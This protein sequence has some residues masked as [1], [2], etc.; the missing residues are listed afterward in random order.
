MLLRGWHARPWHARAG[1]AAMR[2][3]SRLRRP[4]WHLLAVAMAPIVAC[5][6][7]TDPPPQP[8][9][10]VD[11]A[12]TDVRCPDKIPDQPPTMCPRL[13]NM[14]LGCGGNG[15]LHT[16]IGGGSGKPIIL[17]AK[18]DTGSVFSAVLVVTNCQDGPREAVTFGVTYT[19]QLA[20][21]DNGPPCIARS[22]AVYSQFQFGDPFFGVFE[23]LARDKMHQALDD[24]A[25]TSFTSALGL[26]APATPRCA[27]WREM[28]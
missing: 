6:G 4:I 1:T 21:P 20:T 18:L 2:R 9:Q 23:G 5:G 27:L 28:P 11:T 19:G 14:A 10:P 17:G 3:L 7:H 25:I 13:K 26:T 15:M 16:S 22:K 24:Q 12:S 8:T